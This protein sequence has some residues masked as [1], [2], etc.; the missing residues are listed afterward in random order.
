MLFRILL[1]VFAFALPLAAAPAEDRLDRAIE[2]LRANRVAEA[3]AELEA[4]VE[5]QPGNARAHAYLAAAEIKTGDV[6]LAITRA[7]R[8]LEAD[9]DDADVH[10]LLGQARM[11]NRQW[12]EAEKHWR[13]VIQQRPNSEEA[14]FQLATTLLQLGNT[15]EGLDAV[16]RAVE[17]NPRRS[18]ARALRGNL[19]AS[20]GRAEEG[21]KEWIGALA[22][23]GNNV[24]ALSG[25]AVHLRQREPE[26]ALEHARRAVELS[27]WEAAAPIRILALVHRSRGDVEQAREVLRRGLRKLPD[28][29]ALAAELRSL[30][31]EKKPAASR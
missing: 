26:Q 11:L 15:K 19:L 9:P 6:E 4:I 21:A 20:I 12:T 1:V 3:R 23:D 18:D 27:N 16:T 22:I 25:L 29:P 14:H 10:D 31:A 5:A 28:E 2:K 13:A 8:L 24:A 30:Q 17:I 7:R